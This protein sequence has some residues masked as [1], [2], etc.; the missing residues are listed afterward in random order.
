MRRYVF[1]VCCG[2]FG[3][4]AIDYSV[5]FSYPVITMK[6]KCIDK[7]TD[8]AGEEYLSIL[9]E[10]STK[11]IVVHS[12][13]PEGL[14][15]PPNYHEPIQFLYASKG[16]M[17]V[18]TSQGCWVVPET[19]A[20]WIPSNVEHHFYANEHLILHSLL[21][22]PDAIATSNV[23]CQVVGVPALL[24][25]MIISA[26]DFTPTYES[27]SYEERFI[28][29]ILDLLQRL[30]SVPFLLP[31]PQDSRLKTITSYLIAHPDDTTPIEIW[32][33]KVGATSRTLSRL[34]RKETGLSFKQWRRQA[35]IQEAIR[36]LVAGEQV[37]SIAFT[38]GYSGVSAFVAMFRK[39]LGC[40]PGRYLER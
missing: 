26:A 33:K 14:S 22:N 24:R 8:V 13:H 18:N 38:L 5:N 1:S 21:I 35:K 7:V 4:E 37:S 19:H 12:N 20:V 40:S 25:E 36:L 2:S 23:H 32:A 3:S 31:T 30:E 28:G 11:L 39:E 6:T 34:F 16:V 9:K 10:N 27:G 17:T 29:I 15:C